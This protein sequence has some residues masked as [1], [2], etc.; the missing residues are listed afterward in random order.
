MLN[1]L[2]NNITFLVALVAA[3]QLLLSRFDGHSL[4]RRAWLGVLFGSV[5]LLGMMNPVSFMPGVIFD[6]RS[7]VL[8]VAG[9]VGG[10]VTA[11]I[12]AAMAAVYRY[13]MGGGGAVV[14]IAVILQSALLGVLARQWWMRR[15]RSPTAWDF[16]GLGVLVQLGQLLAFTQLPGGVGY[17]FIAQAWWV[18]LLFYPLA[19]T[20]LC[21]IFQNYERQRLDHARLKEAQAEVSRERAILRTLIDSLPDLIWLKDPQ[22]RYLACN[23]RFEQFFGAP[24]RAIVGR[25]D[26]DFVPGKL[27]DFFRAND[28]KAMERGGPSVNEEEIVF[29]SDGHREFLETTKVPMRDAEGRLIGVLGIGHDITQRKQS[30]RALEN[31]EKQLRF[32]LEGSELGFWDWDIVTGKVDRNVRWAEMLG[33]SHAEI[34]HTPRQWT[35][36]I[37]PDDRERA[38]NSIQA[39]LDGHS[40]IHRIEY[41][42]LHKAGGVRWILDQASVMQRDA[43]GK[44]LRMC[45]THTDITA[46]KEAEA[47]LRES[48]ARYRHLVENMPDV[49]Y[50]YSVRRGGVYYSA[51]VTEILGYGVEHLLKQPRLWAESI[52]PED[53]PAVER[54]VTAL[55]DRQIPFRLEYRIRNAEGQWLWLYDRSIDMKTLDD[56]DTLIEGL[57]MDITAT[58]AIR[59]ELAEHHQHLERIVEERTRE[60]V[61]AKDAAETANIAKSVFLANMS[62]ELRTPL[63]AILGFS[64]LLESDPR[65]PAEVRRSIATINRSGN[66]LLA[67]INDVLEIA[68]IES[69]RTRV[70]Q[71]P[72]DLSATLATVEEMIQLRAE[73]K[74]LELR[75]ERADDLPVHVLGDS[76]R[77]RQVLINLLGNAVKYTD[78]GRVTLRVS[79]EHDDRLRFEV[80]DTGPGIAAAELERIFEPFHQTPEGIAKGE[81]TGL[82]LTISRDFV[83]LMGGDGIDVA[84]EL[85]RGSRF[86]FSIPLPRVE[87][88]P[89]ASHRRRVIGLAPGQT[90]PRILVAEDHPD[91]Q[92][93][94]QELLGRIGAEV[95]IAANGREAIELFQQWQPRLVLMDMRMPVMDGYQATRAIRGLPGGD[96]TAIVAVTASAFE[97]DRA[98]VLAAGCDAL[99]R[100]PIEAEGMFERIAALLGIGFEYGEDEAGQAS[101]G[102]GHGHLRALPEE[103]RA[104]LMQSALKLDKEVLLRLAARIR[105][106][107]PEESERI[108]QLVDEYRY[109]RIE[110]LCRV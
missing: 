83:R 36:F 101:A 56:G 50:V 107:W 25:T 77:L 26:H 34:Q 12:A 86:G 67:L 13:Q 63:N 94:I 65:M 17:A 9:V 42:M 43:D 88:S 82:G 14:G 75:I 60:L 2:I 61:L 59:D 44:P 99:I 100:K 95:R 11:A 28:L 27:A 106:E 20:L 79:R 4:N 103:I 87:A 102:N 64:Q 72:F 84:S 89:A 10:G 62:H 93:L 105:P 91:N 66:H 8:A 92:R 3:G 23:H 54:A 76:H 7:I 85:G 6:G 46:R 1:T 74:G 110:D 19:T 33:Y 55:L 81:G 22:G 32:V 30:E 15:G 52:H 47:T 78:H 35:D 97:E 24:E 73:S 80:I 109:D 18:L 57:A 70:A 37:H 71:E 68:R 40:S 48:E 41:R 38:W 108:I 58:K 16:I 49:V 45:G 53:R 96:R 51:R 5:T 104:E 29:A 69:G 31:S 21:L 90:P 98:H 39:V